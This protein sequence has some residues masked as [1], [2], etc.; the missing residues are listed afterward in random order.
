MTDGLSEL[1]G[2]A[3]TALIGLVREHTGIAMN[4]RKGVLLQGRL[5]SRIRALGL[6]GYG[7]Y[8]EH[9]RRRGD[10]VPAFISLVTTNDTAF[11]RTPAVWEYFTDVFL[12]R[13]LRERPGQ[14]LRLWSAAAATGEEAY[15]LA[16]AC[17]DFQQANPAFRFRI[18]ATD[19]SPDALCTAQ[20]AQY[21]GRTVDR[22]RDER[23]E[24]FAR[25]M[26]AEGG[27]WA[28]RPEVRRHVRFGQHHL[29][30]EHRADTYDMV[31]LRN[32]LMYFDDADQR[33]VL[34]GV[35][36]ALAPAGLLVLGEQDAIAR[37]GAPFDFDC[38]HVWR[39]EQA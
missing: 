3:L 37:L 9:V 36:A 12:P 29:L 32:V 2:P 16:M 34:R 35:H 30:R 18:D 38:A 33:G 23:P 17:V 25:H 21:Q 15:S 10:E 11:F 26:A 19:I 28:V 22:F 24:Q 5:R 39:K 6:A 14:T 20:A 13:W 4:E 7:A 1:S 8:I 27:G 31:F